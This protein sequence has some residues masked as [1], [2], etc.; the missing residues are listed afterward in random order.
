VTVGRVNQAGEETS[1]RR[2]I[3][4]SAKALRTGRDRRLVPVTHHSTTNGV[5]P[6]TAP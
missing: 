6:R 5:T 3:Q 4:L 1:W 2:R